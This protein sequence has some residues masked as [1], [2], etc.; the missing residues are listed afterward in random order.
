M[1]GMLD[2]SFELQTWHGHMTLHHSHVN[3][4]FNVSKSTLNIQL[5]PC[6]GTGL[7][8]SMSLCATAE[9]AWCLLPPCHGMLLPLACHSC[10]SVVVGRLIVS[11]T[12]THHLV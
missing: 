11:I 4:K 7:L 8:A 12:L 9:L 2:F 1:E 3:F 6:T 5:V 10:V